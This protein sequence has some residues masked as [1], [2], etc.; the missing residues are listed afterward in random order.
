MAAP[1]VLYDVASNLVTLYV[2]AVVEPPTRRG[3]L[4]VLTVTE[5][6]TEHPDHSRT[7]PTPS[8]V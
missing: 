5:T 1:Q 3:L 4:S 6:V 2:D 8:P 7:A